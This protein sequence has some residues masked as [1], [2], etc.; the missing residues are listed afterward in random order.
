MTEIW[1]TERQ[2]EHS[3]LT[4]RVRDV[5]FSGKS[6]YQEIQILDTYSLGKVLVLD[7]TYQTTERDE[8]YYHEAL[9]HIPLF[10]H[11]N[12]RHVLVVGGGDGGTVREVLKHKSV[13]SVDLVE[14]DEVVVRECKKHMPTLSKGFS[15][16]RVSVIFEDGAKYVKETNKKYDVVIVDSPDPVGPAVV[17]FEKEFYEN[18]K[19][20][21][22]DGGLMVEQTESPL[23]S[24]D[25]V[26][27][28]RKTFSE[29]FPI[30]RQYLTVVYTYPG[31]TWSFTMG[32]LKHDPLKVD[33][34]ELNKRFKGMETKIYYPGIHKAFFAL[35]R[36]I[37]EEG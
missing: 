28:I 36:Y 10:T 30:V 8:A 2:E 11:P 4:V 18:I 19:G 3:G 14:I 16:E 17:L 21:L 12:P 35:P 27:N 26:I 31:A 1:F 7:N 25:F 32:S 9:A 24:K 15:D 13:E 5:L 22:N 20:I 29:V 23:F 37:K 33:E 34:E 6:K